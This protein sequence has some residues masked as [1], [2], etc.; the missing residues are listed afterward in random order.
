MLLPS[1]L[2]LSLLIL[3]PWKTLQ[4]QRG[5][6]II[7]LT[8]LASAWKGVIIQ[9]K[10]SLVKIL[11]II[12]AVHFFPAGMTRLLFLS[13]ALQDDSTSFVVLY[14]V[15]SG[16][17]YFLNKL[18]RT[19]DTNVSSSYSFIRYA[20]TCVLNNFLFC[21]KKQHTHALLLI[22]LITNTLF[23]INPRCLA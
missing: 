17:F 10:W 7:L 16:S 4:C 20:C 9:H 21:C 18:L 2:I 1:S 22:F 5:P 15:T 6:F 11:L 13:G 12:S 14:R 8:V 23:I 19:K 3:T